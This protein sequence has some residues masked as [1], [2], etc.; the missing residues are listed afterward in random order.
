MIE[1]EKDVENKLRKQDCSE[2][3]L[4]MYNNFNLNQS[5]TENE[6]DELFF[7]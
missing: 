4:K 7:L 2:I 1:E 5:V 6:D 3:S